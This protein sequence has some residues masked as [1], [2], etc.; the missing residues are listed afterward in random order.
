MEEDQRGKDL[1][2]MTHHEFE[3]GE[4]VDRNYD[5]NRYPKDMAFGNPTPHNNDGKHVAKSLTWLRNNDL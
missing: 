4:A 1:Y 3:V 2:K 5:W